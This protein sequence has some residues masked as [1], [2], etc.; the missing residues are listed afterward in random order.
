MIL[1]ERE[2]SFEGIAMRYNSARHP[3]VLA[4]RLSPKIALANFL[5]TFDG[6]V[7]IDDKVTREE[8]IDYYTNISAAIDSDEY[9]DLL[10]RSV[11]DL[12]GTA[13]NINNE[14]MSNSMAINA[15]SSGRGGGRGM[16]PEGN[17]MNSHAS[18]PTASAYKS[19]LRKGSTKPV[20]NYKALIAEDEVMRNFNPTSKSDLETSQ[21]LKQRN[22]DRSMLRP[23]SASAVRKVNIAGAFPPANHTLNKAIPYYSNH[24]GA[25]KP[26]SHVE[27]KSSHLLG[28]SNNPS[29]RIPDNGLLLIIARIKAQ[30]KAK[31]PAGFTS[32]QR[33]FQAYDINGDQ[34]LSRVEFKN[35]LQSMNLGI[36]ENETRKMFEFFDSDENEFISFDEFINGLRNPLSGD[37]LNVVQNAFRKLDIKGNGMLDISFVARQYGASEHPDVISG[38]ITEKQAMEFFLDTLDASG[39]VEGKITKKEF[40]NYYTN[41]GA[42][43][44]NDEYF[45]SLLSGVW[46]LNGDQRG[47]PGYSSKI[48]GMGELQRPSDAINGNKLTSQPLNDANAKENLKSLQTQAVLK[49]SQR[50]YS[51]AIELFTNVLGMMHQIYPSGHPECLKIHNSIEASKR[52]QATI[53]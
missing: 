16:H 30:L 53:T 38:K 13:R 21:N 20:K 42:A 41:I 52:K 4:G 5:E 49:F 28:T 31:G 46:H 44:D 51:K 48:M 22:Q 26:L 11:W 23:K 27:A 14:T 25:E 33:V 8:F 32:L 40:V 12:D 9:F 47:D 45:Q 1:G 7:E 29:E 24:Y 50:N 3:E 35:A 18:L 43:I 37:R 10:L 36:K 15:E 2:V 39:E 19:T 34:T 17:S 6:G